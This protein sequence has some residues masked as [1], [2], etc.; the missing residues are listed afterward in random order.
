MSTSRVGLAI[1]KILKDLD[2]LPAAIRTK[3]TRLLPRPSRRTALGSL[4]KL[5]INGGLPSALDSTLRG[6]VEWS[7]PSILYDTQY[8]KK[9]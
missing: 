5:L 7:E 9:A 2:V 1:S 6:I 4:C 3:E 8:V